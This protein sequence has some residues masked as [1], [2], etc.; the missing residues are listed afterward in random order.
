MKKPL[1]AHPGKLLL[2]EFIRPMNL[3]TYRVAKDSA[4]PQ[5][6]LAAIVAGH[7]SISPE[8]AMRLGASTS[9]LTPS[10]G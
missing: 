10:S 1:P 8:T 9:G 3:S 5:S 4:I 7:R 2:E 6:T